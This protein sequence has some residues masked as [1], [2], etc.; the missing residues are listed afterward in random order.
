V[1]GKRRN[2]VTEVARFPS[3]SSTPV[4]CRVPSGQVDITSTRSL[5]QSCSHRGAGLESCR[6]PGRCQSVREDNVTY[7]LDG[8][9][10]AKSIK[11]PASLSR[12]R[13]LKRALRQLCA[14]WFKGVAQPCAENVLV[15]NCTSGRNPALLLKHLAVRC[16]R[17]PIS[18]GPHCW[19]VAGLRLQRRHLPAQRG[20]LFAVVGGGRGVAGCSLPSANARNKSGGRLQTCA[21]RARRPRRARSAA[22]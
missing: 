18:L 12:F 4:P 10:T 8:A 20:A 3:P 15:F 6:W 16:D 5:V 13:V 1:L 2:L 21:A 14:E 9:H 17:L 7:F 22:S 19:C 11:V